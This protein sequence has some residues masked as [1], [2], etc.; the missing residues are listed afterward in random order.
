MLT[1]ITHSATQEPLP[2]DSIVS[3]DQTLK[4]VDAVMVDFVERSLHHKRG[5]SLNGR[6]Q[7]SHNLTASDK[8]R[9]NNNSRFV[10]AREQGA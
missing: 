9:S 5:K 7:S 6:I 1:P 4:T 8:R 2:S 3:S 10:R